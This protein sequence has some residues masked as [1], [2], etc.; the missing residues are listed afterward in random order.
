MGKKRCCNLANTNKCLRAL[1]LETQQTASGVS[2]FFLF[3]FS[4]VL[5]GTVTIPSS[6]LTIK[7]CGQLFVMLA[8]AAPSVY[9]RSLLPLSVALLA[10]LAEHLEFSPAVRFVPLSVRA[11]LLGVWTFPRVASLVRVL[12][13]S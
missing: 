8:P 4:F 5:K 2:R 13:V 1:L 3:C 6:R 11:V 12:F 10:G 7:E 9:V